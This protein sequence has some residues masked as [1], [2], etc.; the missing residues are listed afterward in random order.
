MKKKI[1]FVI[2]EYTYGGTNKSL[3]NLLGLIDHS[4]YDISIFCLYEDGSDYYKK[5]F[6]PYNL[7]KS[8]LYYWLHDN[9]CTRKVMGL[10]NKMTKRDNFTALYKREAR[11]LQKKYKFDMVIAYQEGLATHFVSYMDKVEHKIAWIHCDYSSWTRGRRSRADMMAYS[12]YRDIVCV[13]QSARQSFISVF[14]EYKGKTHFIY[15]MLNINAILECAEK[16]TDKAFAD[17]KSFKV[18]SV[19]RLSS[20]KLFD[21][22]PELLENMEKQ[23]CVSCHWY[24]IGEGPQEGDI[25]KE[26]SSRNMQDRVI[27][28]GAK[29][30]PY[31]YIRQANLLVCTSYSESF[32]YV[33]AEAKALHTPVLS[34][35]FPVAYEVVDEQ[36]GWIVNIK[37]MPQLIVRIISN[38]D[39]EYDRKKAAAMKFEYSNESILNRIDQLFL[40]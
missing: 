36:I 35:D 1:H 18:V 3:E 8:R 29:D 4:K 32:S 16:S 13:S 6:A 34:N 9:V 12:T 24:I 37:D 40:N 17:D 23:Y 33:I 20:V 21:R 14:P 11:L 30:N 31:P 26:I 28:L 7:K 10:Y 39:G 22:I 27:L 15:N 25:R 2:P 19:G 5:L 38:V